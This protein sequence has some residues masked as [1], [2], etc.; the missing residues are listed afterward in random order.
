MQAGRRVRC[1]VLSARDR[2]RTRRRTALRPRSAAAGSTGGRSGGTDEWSGPNRRRLRLAPGPA[3]GKRPRRRHRTDGEDAE[4][5]EHHGCASGVGHG[6]N[7]AARLPS[8]RKVRCQE[9]GATAKRPAG[10]SPR[11]TIP[12]NEREGVSRGSGAGISG[13]PRATPY[14]VG[15]NTIAPPFMQYRKPVGFGPSSNT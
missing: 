15:L 9:G 1:R 10:R 8:I 14:D 3:L 7:S 2:S 13:P 12:A 5:D 6:Q 11:L 4:A